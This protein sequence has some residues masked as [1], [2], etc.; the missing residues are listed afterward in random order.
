MKTDTATTLRASHLTVLVVDDDDMIR[1][2]IIQQLRTI[3]FQ[4]F[5]EAANGTE[6]HKF[7][8]DPLQRVDLIICDWEMPKTDGLTFLRAVR[9]SRHRAQ[10][11][12]IMVTSQQSQE[13]MK[14]SKAKRHEVDAYIVKPFRAEILRAKVFQVLFDAI[15]KK[16]IGV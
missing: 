9:A 3:G 1:N 12:F 7:I 10:T 2:I 15:D 11:P 4:K 14:I 13:R 16:A 8:L 6:A 5:I